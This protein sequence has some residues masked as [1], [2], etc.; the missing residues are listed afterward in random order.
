MAAV[1]MQYLRK[2]IDFSHCS[3]GVLHQDAKSMKCSWHH[4][5][6]LA[7][8][9]WHR[10]LQQKVGQT[11]NTVDSAVGGHASQDQIQQHL[12]PNVTQKPG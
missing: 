7:A 1:C 3:R 4:M 11:G 10:R 8:C 12:M 2:H 9:Q 6:S 5:C